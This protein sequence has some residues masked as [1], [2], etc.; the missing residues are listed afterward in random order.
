MLSRPLVPAQIDWAAD[1]AASSPD[2]DDID[3][4]WVSA[5]AQAQHVF[6]HGNGLPARWQ[7]QDDF[8][9]AEVGFGL[10]YNFISTWQT[11]RDDPTRCRRLHYVALDAH[12]PRLPDLQQV[13]ADSPCAALSQQLLQA[14]PPLVPGLHRLDFEG[15]QVQLTLAFGDARSLG[16]E[17]VFC[18]DAVYLDF[19]ATTRN[20]ALWDRHLL[21]ALAR[22]SRRGTTLAARSV[23]HDLREGL[24][25][26]GFDWQCVPGI[27]A[28][29]EIL[30]AQYQ[31]RFQGHGPPRP[32]PAPSLSGR[33]AVVVGA[34]LAGASCAWALAQQGFQ[35]HVLD[36]LAQPAQ[37]SSGN[38]AGLFHATVHGDDNPYARLFRAAALR[39]AQRLRDEPSH[40]VPQGLHGLLRLETALTV[41]EMAGRISRQCLPED[42]VRALTAEQASVLAGV[43][44]AAPAWHY[45]GAGWVSPGDLVRA[46]L[47]HPQVRF[48]GLRAVQTLRRDGDDWVCVDAR[49]HDLARA[50]QLV[51]A[52]AEQANILLQTLGWRPWPLRRT[53]GQVS[54][55]DPSTAPVPLRLPV[56]GDGYALPLP[57]GG[58]LCG[59]T[60]GD[61][62]SD[63]DSDTTPRLTD[64]CTNFERLQRLCGLRPPADV[65]RW[66]G[67]VGWRVQPADRLPLVGP[68]PARQI[69]AGTRLDQARLVPREPGLH[70]AC[71]LGARGITLAPL[72][73]ELVAARIA[74]SPWPL[75][76]SL[77]DIVDPARWIVRAARKAGS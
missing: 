48:E 23:A 76:Q 77:A 25:A 73:G 65:G 55:F 61:D 63:D 7:G 1:G 50:P 13:H 40:G 62:D 38:P 12:P 46:W 75:E 56:A 5:Q 59:A 29:R 17:L 9:V 36:R 74:G 11:W 24:A 37:A 43:P 18:A 3:Q 57:G 53:R 44:L 45:P 31:P 8:T 16:T 64:H 20:A 21:K 60:T 35:V 41:A 39:I 69:T 47:C 2:V 42:F 51:L 15:G 14:W 6:L 30:Q 34:G 33:R 49:G 67:R 4:P 26:A 70:L 52:H 68:V 22:R 10:G 19:M 32:E 28:Q 72:L 27:G 58:L 71:G 54:L 66:Q